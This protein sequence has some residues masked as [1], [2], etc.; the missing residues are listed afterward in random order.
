M[1][2]VQRT[3]RARE[4]VVDESTRA[5]HAFETDL[6]EDAG[7]V[8]DVVD[9]RLN[10]LPD[11]PQLREHTACAFGQRRIVEQR[12]AGEAGRED[13]RVVLRISFPCPDLF[14]L[15]ESRPDAC[16]ERWTLEPLG[17]GQ[18]GGIYGAQA[19]REPSKIPD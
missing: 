10:E 11:L 8:L 12:L 6:H 1:E 14:E 2:V 17:I 7:G 18:T 5:A 3:E 13:F 15:E 16:L 19:A 4:V 9:G